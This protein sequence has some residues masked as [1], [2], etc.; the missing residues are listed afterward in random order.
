MLNQYCSNSAKIFEYQEEIAP[1]TLKEHIQGKFI[2]KEKAR[3]EAILKLFP[4]SYLRKLKDEKT[5]YCVKDESR[6][7][8]G[9]R[10]IF[11]EPVDLGLIK[12]NQFRPFQQYIADE[13]KLKP[14]DRH[15]YWFYDPKGNCGK[16]ALC[17]YLVSNNM[18]ISIRGG[19]GNDILHMCAESINKK[20]LQK[21][22]TF[23]IDFPR[24]LEGKISY[25]A[26]ENIKDGMWT[27]TKYEGST[28]IIPCPHV[29]I[30]ANWL[31]DK[32]QMSEDRWKIFTVDKE[33][34]ND[35][36]ALIEP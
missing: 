26:I 29:F 33:T 11:P 2:L 16:T 21:W 8:N 10:V 27:S 5:G 30:F 14:N 32:N 31:P 23:L 19:K 24:Q 1:T 25:C 17:K 18:G 35:Y 13:Q 15:I 3:K 6:K 4:F 7:P 9:I 28:I 20:P 34:I 12:P 22:E 36:V